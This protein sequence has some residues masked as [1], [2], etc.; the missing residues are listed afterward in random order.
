[1]RSTCTSPERA[2]SIEV[3]RSLPLSNPTN[4]FAAT[5]IVYVDEESP[6]VHLEIHFDSSKS[7]LSTND[8]PDLDFTYSVNPYRG[9]AHA[10]SYCYARPTHEYLSFGAGT[11]FDRKIVVKRDAPDL[12][13]AAL[14]SPKWD[15]SEVLVFS[16]VTDPY[17]P[18]ERTYGLTRAC[19]EV[20]ADFAQPTS[21][22]TKGVTIERDVDVLAD[23]VRRA[24]VAVTISIPFADEEHARALEP[25]VTTPTRRFRTIETL[26]KAGIPV[27]VN[28]APIIP[29]L[30]DQQM[31]TILERAKD[32]GAKWA[33]CTLLRLPGSTKAVFES[34][35]REALPLR[36]EKVIARLRE[37]H[38]GKMYDSTFGR[39]GR[40]DGPYA[41]MIGA[42]FSAAAER[43]GLSGGQPSLR[44]PAGARPRGKK[45]QLSL[46]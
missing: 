35:L 9:C 23:L 34:R 18:L 2:Y 38:G 32:A 29:G 24:A 26:A 3:A 8:S 30:S 12:L 46:F 20:C 33:G 7:I 13:R 25:F 45:A 37:A 39:R 21:I 14:R 41:D 11:D 17:Q 27:G 42:L 16:G 15:P 6:P 36:A 44:A 1:M 10:C 5:E 40:G 22:I 31:V 19:L 4:P 43:L 28:V